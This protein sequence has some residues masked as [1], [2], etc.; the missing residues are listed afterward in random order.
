MNG[1]R[2]AARRRRW[3]RTQALDW[4]VHRTEKAVGSEPFAAS[5][6]NPPIEMSLAKYAMLKRAVGQP[7]MPGGPLVHEVD[8]E[9]DLEAAIARG[10]LALD[11]QGR[12]SSRDVRA[13]WPGAGR[14]NAQSRALPP[15]IVEALARR[16]REEPR[17]SGRSQAALLNDVILDQE[18]EGCP[19]VRWKTRKALFAIARWAAH[20]WIRFRLAGDEADRA[21]ANVESWFTRGR[22]KSAN[23]DGHF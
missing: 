21:R 20:G 14:G 18:P 4:I 12:V 22:A 19:D 2:H 5:R 17:R 15:E 16:I 8:A 23:S 3:T 10:A 11:R 6:D 7:Y 9:R 13:L 1:N